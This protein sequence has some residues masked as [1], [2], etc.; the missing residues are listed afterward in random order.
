MSLFSGMSLV[1]MGFASVSQLGME[2]EI[3]THTRIKGVDS[4]SFIYEENGEVRK[5]T[6]TILF[7]MLNL[8][9]G[10]IV[11]IQKG[12][13]WVYINQLIPT[14]VILHSINFILFLAGGIA[15]GIKMFR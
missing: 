8:H 14:L 1:D 15:L 11:K 3:Y 2:G 13:L 10:A 12:L 6:N 9:E 5:G 7:A 4:I